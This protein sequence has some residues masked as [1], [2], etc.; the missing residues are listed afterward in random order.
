MNLAASASHPDAPLVGDVSSKR[1][2]AAYLDLGVAICI[3]LGLAATIKGNVED[4]K[5]WVGIIL[6]VTVGGYYFLSEG[7][8]GTTPLKW[9]NGLK[10]VD[11]GGGRPSWRQVVV[12]NFIRFFEIALAGMLIPGVVA[13]C[14]SR[15]QRIGDMVAGTLVVKAGAT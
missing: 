1:A 4:S 14:S 3:G 7:F 6:S 13:V 9:Y 5:E 2:I 10:V 8:F 11:L 12:R 15:G